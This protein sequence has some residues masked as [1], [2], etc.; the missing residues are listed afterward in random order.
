MEENI[1]DN[2]G[3]YLFIFKIR[4]IKEVNAYIIILDS[5]QNEYGPFVIC[6]TI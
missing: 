1:T 4:M 6:R 2:K 3:V 5:S